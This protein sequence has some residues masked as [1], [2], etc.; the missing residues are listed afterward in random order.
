MEEER[1]EYKENK[2]NNGVKVKKLR[3]RERK[4]KENGEKRIQKKQKKQLLIKKKVT[5]GWPE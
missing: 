5:R 2:C 3:E 4:N 1:V